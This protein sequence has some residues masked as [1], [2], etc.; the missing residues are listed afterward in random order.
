[1]RSKRDIDGLFSAGV[2]FKA[3]AAA[4]KSL[5]TSK[6]KRAFDSIRKRRNLFPPIVSPEAEIVNV[7]RRGEAKRGGA[8][9][10]D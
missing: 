10:G 5:E 2:E 9:P 7:A 3:A 6:G 4:M 1:M 8:G